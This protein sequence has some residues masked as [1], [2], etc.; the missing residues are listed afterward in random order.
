MRPVRA[1][2]DSWLDSR[3]GWP[4]WSNYSTADG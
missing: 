4:R 3:S 2:N 1:T